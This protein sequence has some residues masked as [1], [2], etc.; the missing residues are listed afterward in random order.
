MKNTQRICNPKWKALE[1]DRSVFKDNIEDLIGIE[2][3]TE[4]DLEDT[5]HKVFPVPLVLSFICYL[6]ALIGM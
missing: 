4:Y 5:L 2:E 1:I 6:L 3:C